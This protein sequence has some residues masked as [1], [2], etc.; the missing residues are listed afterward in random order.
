MLPRHPTVSGMSLIELLVLVALLAIAAFLIVPKFL[1]AQSQAEIV[2]ANDA[3]GKLNNTY[4]QWVSLGGGIGPSWNLWWYCDGNPNDDLCAVSCIFGYLC[5]AGYSSPQPF[6]NWVD[7]YFTQDNHDAYN[8][9][10]TTARATNAM[11]NQAEQYNAENVGIPGYVPMGPVISDSYGQGGSWTISF[12][13]T[14]MSPPNPEEMYFGPSVYNT[15]TRAVPDG[16]YMPNDNGYLY[17]K[18]GNTAYLIYFEPAPASGSWGSNT[19]T[20]F[21]INMNDSNN[22][23]L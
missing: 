6:T 17:Y 23:N 1:N 12:N 4:N 2:S 19:Q 14:V 5:Q 10:T 22:L 15:I 9:P 13:P 20:G 18:A 7:P 16:F 3:I 21:W 8:D 11:N